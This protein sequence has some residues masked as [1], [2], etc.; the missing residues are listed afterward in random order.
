MR[1]PVVIVPSTSENNART[2]PRNSDRGRGISRALYSMREPCRSGDEPKR[3]VLGR[4][5]ADRAIALA[6]QPIFEV[7]A[8]EAHDAADFENWQRIRR[9]PGHVPAPTLR[10]AE[11]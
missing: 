3:E 9:A 4:R 1:S 2:G 10:A 8:V 5:D 11:C 6:R 7:V